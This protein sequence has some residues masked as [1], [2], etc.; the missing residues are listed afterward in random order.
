MEQLEVLSISSNLLAEIPSSLANVRRCPM[1][2]SHNT[3][4]H[5]KS[6]DLFDI[7]LSLSLAV[8]VRALLPL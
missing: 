5:T 6:F 4:S 7:S 1:S 8:C 2:Y 3:E